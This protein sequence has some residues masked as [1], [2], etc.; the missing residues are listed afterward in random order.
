MSKHATHQR[1][2]SL[3]AASLSK[4]DNTV[5]NDSIFN[6]NKVCWILYEMVG[7]PSF[8]EP[9]LCIQSPQKISFSTSA[10]FHLP[11]LSFLVQK[12]ILAIPTNTP[13]L[14]ISVILNLLIFA[15]NLP[16]NLHQ[17]YFPTSVIESI[18][19][20]SRDQ[21]AWKSFEN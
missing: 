21:E 7:A 10:N 19:A 8:L 16:A 2:E 6:T 12:I 9:I 15:Y 17:K 14:D 3:R 11:T 4:L 20:A 18:Q 5:N 13:F 1:A